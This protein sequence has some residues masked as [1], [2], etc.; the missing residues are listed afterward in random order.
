MS[1]LC[2]N[3]FVTGP[4]VIYKVRFTANPE[5][6]DTDIS[7]AR[8]SQ[9]FRAG[10]FVNPL[11]CVTKTVE[12]TGTSD[13][14]HAVPERLRLEIP[15][16]GPGRTTGMAVRFQLP[17]EDAVALEL[18]D[19]L[20]RRLAFRAPEHFEAGRHELDWGVPPTASG[21]F[22]VRLTTGEGLKTVARWL[23]IR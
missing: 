15:S 8:L 9:F 23:V 1:L 17:R 6:G 16:A 22:I 20:G 10:F 11:D 19:I 14:G 5:L 2:N 12:I 13:A 18:F 3:V 4:G 21:I 7:C